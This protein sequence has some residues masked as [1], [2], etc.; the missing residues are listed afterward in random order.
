MATLRLGALA[1]L[2]SI[3]LV[4]PAS[5]AAIK[6]KGFAS[7]DAAVAA[8]V[9]DLKSNDVHGLRAIF[10]PGSQALINSGDP[11]ADKN[12]RARFVAAFEENHRIDRSEDT[13]T[14]IVGKEDWPMPMPLKKEGTLWR[15]DTAAG[16]RQILDRRIGRNELATIQTVLA[17]VD[18]QRD[19]AQLMAE[20]TGT[21]QYARHFLSRPGKLD[22]LYWPARAGEPESPLGPLI[23]AARAQGYNVARHQGPTPYHGYFFKILT[24][25]GGSAP[26]GAYDYIVK[27]RMIGGFG[28]VAWPARYGDSGVMT[29]IVNHNDVVYQKNLGPRTP[30]IARAMTR[31]DPDPSWQ[32]VNP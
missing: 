2:L 9:A 5:A 18:A 4:A 14:L 21:E 15:F 11:V 6:G 27:G 20:R 1:L 16:E 8:L 3:G 25:Q 24:A 22:G 23:A 13:A 7:P 17:C 10:G 29:F 32:K 31:F 26:G 28:L 12:G 19:Y 30:R